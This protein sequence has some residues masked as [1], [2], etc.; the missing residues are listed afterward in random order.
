MSYKWNIGKNSMII[1]KYTKKDILQNPT[2]FHD[3]K[4]I[5]GIDYN[6]SNW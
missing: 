5:V 2:H 4:K 3:Q 1:P 6:L